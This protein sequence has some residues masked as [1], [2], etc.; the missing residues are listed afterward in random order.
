MNFTNIFV[1][2]ALILQNT[3]VVILLKYSRSVERDIETLGPR[4][5]ITST[6][7]VSEICKIIIG[8]FILYL[9]FRSITEVY[10]KIFG[11]CLS[12]WKMSIPSVLYAFE[13][14]LLFVALTHLPVNILQVMLMLKI[15]S[16][17]IFSMIM[18]KEKFNKFEWFS[19]LLLG[20]GAALANLSIKDHIQKDSNTHWISVICVLIS[21]IISGFCGNYIEL[22]VKE[23]FDDS[24]VVKSIQMPIFSIIGYIPCS[25]LNGDMNITLEYGFFQGFTHITWYIIVL[26]MLLIYLF[27]F[28]IKY[29]SNI[30]RAFIEGTSAV[31]VVIGSYVFLDSSINYLFVISVILVL[32]GNII[33]TKEKIKKSDNFSKLN[34]YD[35]VNVTYSNDQIVELIMN[36]EIAMCI[37]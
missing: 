14:V 13:N 26:H 23:D 25:F 32:S 4:F 37:V 29:M 17:A 6:I 36:E 12:L 22:Q 30:V 33:F 27:L 7:I 34:N 35:E 19:F 1:S 5:T 20:L 3:I 10:N 11:N 18:L 31:F 21:I 9:Q 24:I 2:L 16:T 28:V 15:F 8:I